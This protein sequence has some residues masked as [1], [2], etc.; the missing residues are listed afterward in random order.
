ML[1]HPNFEKPFILISDASN[2]AIVHVLLQELEGGLRPVLFCGR[3][4]IEQNNE[5]RYSTTDNPANIRR[6]GD[7]P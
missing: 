4:T 3:T 7:V 2:K 6:L 1:V 5:Q